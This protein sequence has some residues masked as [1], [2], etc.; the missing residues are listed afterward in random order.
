[1]VVHAYILKIEAKGPPTI[2]RFS[3]TLHGVISHKTA[4]FEGYI[5]KTRSQLVWEHEITTPCDI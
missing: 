4:F 1:V 2:R 5:N 3:T